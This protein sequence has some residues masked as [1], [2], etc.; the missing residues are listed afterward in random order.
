MTTEKP[1]S[2]L[3]FAAGDKHASAWL[4]RQPEASS[5]VAGYHQGVRVTTIRL[6]LIREMG[7]TDKQLPSADQL[8][9]YLRNNHPKDDE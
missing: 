7:Y 6:W 3:E 5:I 9:R 4:L 2:L 1:K 8:G